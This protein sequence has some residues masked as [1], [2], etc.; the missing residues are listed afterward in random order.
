MSAKDYGGE[1]EIV[2]DEVENNNI[3]NYCWLSPYYMLELVT[4]L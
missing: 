3:N 1:M 2:V 4:D